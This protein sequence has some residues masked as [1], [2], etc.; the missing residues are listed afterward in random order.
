[1]IVVKERRGV[2]EDLKV[3]TAQHNS[4]EEKISDFFARVHR[5]SRC[6]ILA[7]WEGCSLS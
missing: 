5:L 3:S 1:M 7:N 6:L 4:I 2:N